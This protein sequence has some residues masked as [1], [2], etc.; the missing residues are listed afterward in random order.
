MRLS[1]VAP[2]ASAVPLPVSAMWYVKPSGSSIRSGTRRP[3]IGLQI[4]SHKATAHVLR[5]APVFVICALMAKK[6]IDR[7]F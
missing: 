3:V 1:F 7:Y 4:G 6:W 2:L 5:A